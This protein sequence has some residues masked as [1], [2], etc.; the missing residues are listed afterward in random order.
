[1]KGTGPGSVLARFIIF[2]S[3][4]ILPGFLHAQAP[5]PEAVD[6]HLTFVGHVTEFDEV[7]GK[8]VALVGAVVNVY[9]GSTL[10]ASPTISSNGKFKVDTPPNSDY[11]L[12]ITKSGYITKKIEINTYNVPQVRTEGAFGEYDV[13]IELFKMYPGLDYSCLDQPIARIVYNPA[14]DVDDFD[15]DKVYLA[16]VQACIDNLKRLADEAKKRQKLYDDAIA[17]ADKAFSA[18]DWEGAK[19]TYN[20]ALGIIA[21]EQYPKDQI[22]KCDDE[23]NKQGADKKKYDDAIAAADALFKSGDFTGAKTKYQEASGMKPAE[24]YPKDQIAKCDVELGKLADKKKYDDLISQAD[25]KF[26]ATDFTGAKGIYQQASVMR[27]TEQYPKDQIA[28][29]DA[30]INK[31]VIDKKYNDAIA[32]ADALF[33]SSDWTGAKTKYTEASGIKPA[34]QYP[35]DQIALCDANIAKAGAD[36]KYN[37]LIAQADAKFKASDWAGAKTI[38]QQA[39]DLKNTEQYPKDQMKLCDAALAKVDLDKKYNDAIAAADALFKTS[40]W[41]GAK[42]KYLE[43][44]GLKTAEQYPKDQIKL[45]DANLAKEGLD[46]KYNDL[47]AQADTKFKASD[48][49]GAKTIYQQASAVKSDV[50]YPKDQIAICDKNIQ[51]AKDKPYNDLIAQADDKFKANDWAGAKTLYTQASAM[52]A[53]EQYP[54]DQIKICDANLAKAG[55][56]K[57]YNDLIAQADEKFKASDWAG[58]KTIYQQASAVKSDVQYP[59]DQIAKCDANALADIDKK[60]K[61]ALAA[62]DGLF[63]TSDWENAK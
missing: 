18:K 4:A 40:D 48:W 42:A 31:S 27:S 41:A 7:K 15:Y 62:A 13:E 5:P 33:K 23:L 47:I 11:I 45:C 60:Y 43:A 52:K 54:K 49:A 36:K 21:T 58:A 44:S 3:L 56:D 9:A 57:K 19:A 24:Q 34:E 37:D 17:R 53:T 16:K 1:M 20:E 22:A 55:V 6:W 46:K 14:P 12:T 2:F 50:Q 30:E 39:S 51:A 61:D 26:A 32:A 10:V 38:Y 59:K 63:K 8:D 35:K 29:C 25:A 28:K